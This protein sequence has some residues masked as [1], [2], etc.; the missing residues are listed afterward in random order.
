MFHDL[1]SVPVLLQPMVVP[2]PTVVSVTVS[3]LIMTMRVRVSVL[4]RCT[5]GGRCG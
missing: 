2:M 1:M 3:M 5:I 4:A